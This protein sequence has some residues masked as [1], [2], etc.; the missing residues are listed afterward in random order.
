MTLRPNRTAQLVAGAFAVVGAAC[1]PPPVPEAPP[2]GPVAPVSA[3]PHTDS[4]RLTVVESPPSAAIPVTTAPAATAA[5][6]SRQHP[7]SASVD[8]VAAL[9]SPGARSDVSSLPL[10]AVRRVMRQSAA[11]FKACHDAWQSAHPGEDPLDHVS[12]E[13]SGWP[14]LRF[15]I[16]ADGSVTDA[17]VKCEPDDVRTSVEAALRSLAF[18]SPGGGAV[19]VTYP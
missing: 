11:R 15:T 18:P 5:T 10:E 6:E 2:S 13:G 9:K 12:S 16:G 19:I 3:S 14:R 17:Q 7:C 4:D 8:P 1:T